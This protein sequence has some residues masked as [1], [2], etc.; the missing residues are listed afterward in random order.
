MILLFT[1][2]KLLVVVL[3]PFIGE[4]SQV[5]I[6]V[7]S[8]GD[9]QSYL[10]FR[11]RMTIVAVET[12]KR[13]SLMISTEIKAVSPVDDMQRY[14]FLV[15]HV[16]EIPDSGAVL[17]LTA[18]LKRF[19]SAGGF[20]WVYNAATP[21]K[22]FAV[23]AWVRKL[24]GQLLPEYPLQALGGKSIIYRS[25]Y[26][27]TGEKDLFINEGAMAGEDILLLY[28]P[29]SF[30]KVTEKQIRFMINV[31]EYAVCSNYKDEQTHI[32]YI[33]KKRNWK[34]K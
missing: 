32:E 12:Q 28:T 17:A 29:F 15:L 14:P 24:A 22:R 33:L 23:D 31:I 11:K 21:E 3:L 16:E 18:G 8:L 19:I 27:L 26:D 5:H 25:F 30:R 4:L 2:I 10:T 7:I 1:K 9:H 34:L 13:T 6:G 20:L